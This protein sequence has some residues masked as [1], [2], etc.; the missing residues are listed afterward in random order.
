MQNIDYININTETLSNRIFYAFV[1]SEILFFILDI[2]INYNRA[3]DYGPVRRLF[4]TAREDSLSSWFMTAQTLLTALTLWLITY[5]YSHNKERKNF[6]QRGWLILALFF[7]YLAADDGAKIHERLGST[8]KLFMQEQSQLEN[9]FAPFYAYFP[10]Y[11]WQFLLLPFFGA[12]GIFMLIFLWRVFGKST[13]MIKIVLALGFL[14]TAVV[15]DFIEGL[16]KNSPLNLYSL[17]SEYYHLR[18]YTVSHFAKSIEETFEMLG[19]TLFLHTF[20]S[21]LSRV[22]NKKILFSEN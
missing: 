15:L 11:P 13:S 17:L 12:M 16:D 18:D 21:Q 8:F 4:N 14:S 20:I 10:S 19:M 7:T 2:I 6:I 22:T 5:L 1:L 3:I 9:S